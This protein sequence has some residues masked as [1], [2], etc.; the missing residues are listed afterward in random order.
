V[1]AGGRE[2]ARS[3]GARYGVLAS[4]AVSGLCVG[5]HALFLHAQ[6][7]GSEQEY[8]RDE[9]HGQGIF[10][11]EVFADVSFEPSGAVQTVL[12][13]LLWQQCG[14]LP[15]ELGGGGQH[16]DVQCSWLGANASAQLA[17]GGQNECSLMECRRMVASQTVFSFSYLYSLIALWRTDRVVDAQGNGRPDKDRRYVGKWSKAWS[18][19]REARLRACGDM[20][21]SC[22][23]YG[24]YPDCDKWGCWASFEQC[25]G[26]RLLGDPF[27]DFPPPP[28]GGPGCELE[29]P[30]RPAAAFLFFSSLCWPHLKLL[31]LHAAW[32]APLRAAPRRNVLWL[33]A[34]LGKWS[35]SD[36]MVAAALLALLFVNL[37][38]GLA[39][40][41][42]ISELLGHSFPPVLGSLTLNT[43]AFLRVIGEEAMGLF[44]A[45]VLLSLA[46]GVLVDLLDERHRQPATTP[47]PANSFVAARRASNS[48]ELAPS[49]V[50]EI[51]RM[52]A[53]AVGHTL[54]VL[55]TG[56]TLAVALTSPVLRRD[57]S[58]SFIDDV[59]RAAAEAG[60]AVSGFAEDF[61]LLQLAYL[62]GAANDWDVVST[63]H[64]ATFFVFVA[65]GPVLRTVT[66]LALLTLPLSPGV[67]HW[68]LAV[69]QHAAVFYGLDVML[70][71]VPLLQV[72]VENM[73][74]GMFTPQTFALCRDTHCFQLAAVPLRAY[75][76]LAVSVALFLLSGYDG[77]LTHRFLHAAAHPHDVPP[78]SCC[79]KSRAAEGR[80][81]GGVR[82]GEER[83]GGNAGV[84]A[85]GNNGNGGQHGRKGGGSDSAVT[86]RRSSS[87][88]VQMQ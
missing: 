21:P 83:A 85:G 40:N 72:T 53:A 2:A 55:A 34:V 22:T 71:A 56:V 77:S 33:L 29:Y 86:S 67:A 23:D 80:T 79:R 48:G 58:G 63:L 41:R 75:R 62:C 43:T 9:L 14:G 44:C 7:S 45:A 51:E 15:K 81:R 59:T 68:L 82:G 12:D 39:A 76:T 24:P 16:S 42:F 37:N 25:S 1:P 18:R 36:V 28:D 35:F 26:S 13:G 20:W 70:V 11:A 32:Y 50:W 38:A 10:H 64:A 30:G 47:P 57:V 4:L 8:E 17:A 19:E 84:G 52:S 5:S 74:D 88:A 61:N 65:V 73:S 87:V 27:F 46:T 31:A 54:L 6:L 69:S 49:L 60:S 66:Q 78:P 3:L